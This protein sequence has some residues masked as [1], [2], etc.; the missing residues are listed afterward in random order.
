VREANFYSKARSK[1]RSII[2]C[3][4]TTLLSFLL[5]ADEFEPEGP[6]PVRTHSL[7]K[8]SLSDLLLDTMRNY[9]NLKK[10]RRGYEFG[11]LG[12][13]IERVGSQMLEGGEIESSF[14][15][16]RLGLEITKT[17]EFVDERDRK[18]KVLYQV[19]PEWMK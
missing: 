14:S 16:N 3:D 17:G 2:L 11:S 7:Q 12:M 15:L 1:E 19:I 13:Y 9:A 10:R 6:Q 4:S 5:S 18:V 8:E